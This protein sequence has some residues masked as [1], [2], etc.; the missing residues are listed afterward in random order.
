MRLYLLA[1]LLAAVLDA[2]LAVLLAAVLVVVLLVVL[3]TILFFTFSPSIS[4]LYSI[5]IVKK[6][7]ISNE[8]IL[9]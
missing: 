4:S 5:F 9:T 7:F 6:L 3:A 2:V 1:G 8:N